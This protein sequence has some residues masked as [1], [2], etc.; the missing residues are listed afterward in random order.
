VKGTFTS[1]ELPP[2][3]EVERLCETLCREF[4]ADKVY[5]AKRMGYRNHF[6]GGWGRETFVPPR[7]VEIGENIVLFVVGEEVDLK[8]LKERFLALW[9]KSP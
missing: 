1:D 8:A 4:G 7:S 5:L 3:S 2:P 9:K 6:I